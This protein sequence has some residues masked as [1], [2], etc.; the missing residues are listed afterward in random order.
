MTRQRRDV[1]VRQD[2]VGSSERLYRNESTAPFI[3]QVRETYSDRMTC[4]LLTPDGQEIDNVPLM[5][6]AGLVDGEPYGEVCLPAV[7]DYVVVMYAAYGKR[8]K[9]VVGTFIP[10]LT[11]DFVQDVVNSGSKNFTKKLLEADKPLGYRR[12]FKTGTTVEIEEDGGV[13]VETPSGMYFRFDETNSKIF[14]GD[15]Q[16]TPNT[17]TLDANGILIEDTKGNDITMVTGK[18]TIN[19]N[20]E[21]AQ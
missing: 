12:V 6:K 2:A 16:G 10:Y 9:L 3:A 21:V 1:Q 20:L 18:V 7:D 14:F 4:D 5:T 17:I 13:I 15:D 11:N 8:H 19:G